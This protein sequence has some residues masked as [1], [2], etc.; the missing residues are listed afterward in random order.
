MSPAPKP[1]VQR[2][3]R[4]FLLLAALASA[5]PK[6]P[7]AA[8]LVERG[9]SALDAFGAIGRELA[10]AQAQLP[11]TAWTDWLKTLPLTEAQAATFMAFAEIE[12]A[13]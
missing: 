12:A 1:L 7:E 4:L 5:E 10:T 11:E 13:A 3:A 8:S 6:G 9:K 2:A